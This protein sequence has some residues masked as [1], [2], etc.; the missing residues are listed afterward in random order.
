MQ[1][2]MTVAIPCF[3]ITCHHLDWIR[4]SCAADHDAR[5]A[6]R[7]V[8]NG[9]HHRP[10]RCCDSAVRIVGEPVASCST[11]REAE[12]WLVSHRDAKGERGHDSNADPDADINPWPDGHANTNSSADAHANTDAAADPNA[13]TSADPHAN[14]S[15]DPHADPSSYTDADT[16]PDPASGGNQLRRLTASL[17]FA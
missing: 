14:A 15:A 5:G 2:E 7:A 12:G 8:F 10:I 13:N 3:Q 9:G 1:E 16:R 6:N 17:R 4:C 11:Y